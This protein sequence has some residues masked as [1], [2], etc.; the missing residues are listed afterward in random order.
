MRMKTVYLTI[1]VVPSSGKQLLIK[2]KN[3]KIKVYLKNHPENGKANNEL[4]A[5]FSEKLKIVKSDIHIVRG[6]SSR[7]KRIA[8]ATDL[9]FEHVLKKLG[10]EEEQKSFL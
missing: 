7:T 5:F 9:D 2:D 8:V 10:I 6:L 1:I 3:H 4:I